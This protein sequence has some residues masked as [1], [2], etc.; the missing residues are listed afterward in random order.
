MTGDEFDDLCDAYSK[1]AKWNDFHSTAEGIRAL[2][3]EQA[4][5]LCVECGHLNRFD[6]QCLP[7]ICSDCGAV[8]IP[9]DWAER[10]FEN[11][12]NH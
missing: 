6:G 3:Y 8:I 11:Y 2:R 10:M 9:V 7:Y 1:R 12:D 5:I 4:Q